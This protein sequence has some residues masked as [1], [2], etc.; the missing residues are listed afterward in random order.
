MRVT[1]MRIGHRGFSAAAVYDP[2]ME[3]FA[4]PDTAQDVEADPE[5]HSEIARLEAR[6]E[7]LALRLEGCRKYAAA[8]LTAMGLGA[9]LLAAALTRVIQLDAMTVMAAGAAVLGGIVLSGSNR[10]TTREIEAELAAAEAE[11][12]AL[13]GSIELRVV[14]ERPRLH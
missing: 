9:V 10:S 7:E 13:I 4:P 3:Q 8:A 1:K 12:A 6:I 2:A 5:P 11:R 14:S